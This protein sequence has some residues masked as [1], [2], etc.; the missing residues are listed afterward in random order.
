MNNREIFEPTTIYDSSKRG[1]LAFEELRGI[2]KYRELILQLVRRDLISRYKRSTLGIAWTMLNPLGTMLILSFVFSNLFHAVNGYPIY[3]LSGLIA[4]TFF[5]QST[6]ASLSQNVWGSS[7]LQKIYLPRTSFTLS[8]IGTGLV[9]LVLTLVPL[10]LIMSFT[11]YPLRLTMVFLP[12]SITLLAAFSLGI[13]LLFSTLAVYFPDVVDMYQVGLNAWMYLTPIIYPADIIPLPYR[14]WLL[15]LNPMYYFVEIFR[16]PIYD[17][18]LPSWQL[19]STGT[20]IAIFS[21]F[22]GWIVF[23]WQANEFTYRA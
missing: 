13:G 2:L 1:L 12:I 6:T 21:L 4:W 5:S 16:Q 15:A 17:G 8:A 11:G 22:L 9:N 23:T 10:F 18:R 3:V 14:Q 20:G 7:L 19:L